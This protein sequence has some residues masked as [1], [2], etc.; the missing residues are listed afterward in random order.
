MEE[1][2]VCVWHVD[3]ASEVEVADLLRE[4][5]IMKNIGRHQNI[6]N[7]IGCCTQDGKLTRMVSS[8]SCRS[9]WPV[10]DLCFLFLLYLLFGSF[11]LFPLV[12]LSF[13]FFISLPV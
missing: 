11:F 8:G 10:Y 6:I 4:M 13:P 2:P 9:G 5:E 1:T 7:L 12:P 3:G